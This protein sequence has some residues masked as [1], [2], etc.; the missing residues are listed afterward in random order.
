MKTT[1]RT[2]KLLRGYTVT[3]ILITMAI[4]ATLAT[5]TSIIV[6]K[7]KNKAKVIQTHMRMKELTDCLVAFTEEYHFYPY[8]QGNYPTSD[9]AHITGTNHPSSKIINNLIGD[10]ASVNKA[11]VNLLDYFEVT[12]KYDGLIKASSGSQGNGNGGKKSG[13]NGTTKALVDPWGTPYIIIM[14]HDFDGE[15]VFGNESFLGPYRGLVIRNFEYAVISAGPNGIF[16]RVDDINS[17]GGN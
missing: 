7:I 4:I 3:E 11:K 10:N 5:I 17:W 2:G 1:N 6:L 9:K 13:Q 12:D 8:S 14:D 16:D 15:I